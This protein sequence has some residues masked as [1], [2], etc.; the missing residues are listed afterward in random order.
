MKPPASTDFDRITFI[1]DALAH[2][3]SV[4][5][6]NKSQLAF[7]SDLST[8]STCLIL[9]GGT[10]YFLQKLLEQNKTVNITYVD[11]SQKMISHAQKRI[12]KK[13]PDEL[14]RIHF[15][16]ESVE[17][18][19]FSTYDIIVCN[20]FLDLFEQTYVN[21]LAEKF[22]AILN[23]EGILYIT[24]FTIPEKKGFI[25]WSAKKGLKLLYW[26]FKR[27]AS[28]SNNHLADIQSIVLQQGFVPLHSKHFF[29]G[30]LRCSLYR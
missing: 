17:A 16:C 13:M 29:K 1:Y 21:I 5:Q 27:T 24:D 25:Q 3:T 28:L 15:I 2:V 6:I 8:Q 19:D 22:K 23:K 10:G 7:L 14:H 20:Y 26:F 11:A 4:G 30:I 18:F 9:G 12:A